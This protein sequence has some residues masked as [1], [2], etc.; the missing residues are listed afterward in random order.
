MMRMRVMR[1]EE[2]KCS[3]RRAYCRSSSALKGIEAHSAYQS[4]RATASDRETELVISNPH[5]FQPFGCDSGSLIVLLHRPFSPPRLLSLPLAPHRCQPWLSRQDRQ[6]TTS[7]RCA[8]LWQKSSPGSQVSGVLVAFTTVPVA[9]RI[10]LREQLQVA[11][12]SSPW[13]LRRCMSLGPVRVML[14]TRHQPP[15]L[16]YQTQHFL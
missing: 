6:R 4:E 1:K 3:S 11:R 13:N 5:Y 8:R 16:R 2:R 10:T 12:S 14:S 15:L 9:R 7:M